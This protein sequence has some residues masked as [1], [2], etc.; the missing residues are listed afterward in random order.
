MTYKLK[1]KVYIV[2]NENVNVFFN[3]LFYSS[4]ILTKDKWG[5][6][7]KIINKPP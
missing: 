5:H 6:L 7:C 2:H 1:Q 3:V 4:R